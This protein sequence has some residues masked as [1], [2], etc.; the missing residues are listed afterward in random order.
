MPLPEREVYMTAERDV[1]GHVRRMLEK[2][3]RKTKAE[4]MQSAALSGAVEAHIRALVEKLKARQQRR[5]VHQKISVGRGGYLGHRVTRFIDDMQRPAAPIS[6][7]I[8]S[9]DGSHGFKRA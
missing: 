7:G 1:R 3:P 5:S 8:I 4:S 9:L 6:G 2:L